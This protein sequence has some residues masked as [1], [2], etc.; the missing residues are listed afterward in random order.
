MIKLRKLV[1]VIPNF[2]PG[3]VENMCAVTMNLNSFYFLCVDISANVI[4]LVDHQAC[5]AFLRCFV[6]KYCTKKSCSHYQIII[7]LHV[8]HLLFVIVLRISPSAPLSACMTGPGRSSCMTRQKKQQRIFLR[9][10][11]YNKFIRK[12]I[13]LISWTLPGQRHL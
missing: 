3:C 2:F 9:Y 11:Y 10:C 8:R 6:C 4:S 12:W 7:F 1:H 13:V 5:F